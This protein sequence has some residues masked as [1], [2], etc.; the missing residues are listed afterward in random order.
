[1]EQLKTTLRRWGN[2]F[3]VVVPKDIV[4]RQK[5]KEGIEITVTFEPKRAMTGG[6]LMNL[7]R[8]LNLVK[9]LS[10]VDTGRALKEVD[11]EL[12]PEE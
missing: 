2:S 11:R 4:E 3:G 1:M 7:G 12:W 5:L 10:K 8:K 9:K 6:D